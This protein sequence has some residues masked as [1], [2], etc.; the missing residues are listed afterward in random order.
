MP[1][2]RVFVTAALVVVSIAWLAAQDVSGRWTATFTTQVGEQE[3]TFE[4]VQKGTTLTGTA[5]GNLLGKSTIV[6]GKVDGSTITFVENGTYMEMP[7][8]I[9]YTGKVVSGD[10]I[11]FTRNVADIANEELVAKRAK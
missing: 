1:I 9:V 4:F 11:Q 6:D 2:H 5:T 7:L 10:E 8:R 3:Y